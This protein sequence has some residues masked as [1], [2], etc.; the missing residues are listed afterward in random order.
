MFLLLAL[1]SMMVQGQ[2]DLGQVVMELKE[3]FREL[4]ANFTD[5][6]SDLNDLQSKNE[7]LNAAVN[8]LQSKNDELELKNRKLAGEVSFLSN[9]PFYHLCVYQGTYQSNTPSDMNFSHA[10]YYDCNMC[11]DAHFDHNTGM[12][13]NGWPGTYLV[14]WNALLEANHG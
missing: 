2:E 8:A 6:N 13:T 1:Y 14:T 7:K 3:D 12:Y 10:I 9:P 11:D 4:K 5:Q